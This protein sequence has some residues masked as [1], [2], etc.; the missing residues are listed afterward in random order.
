MNTVYEVENVLLHTIA[1]EVKEKCGKGHTRH[2]SS[3]PDYSGRFSFSAGVRHTPRA[4]A[5]QP[6]AN[7]ERAAGEFTLYRHERPATL[8][9][10]HTGAHRFYIAAVFIAILN[11][12]I[13]RAKT[14][15][16]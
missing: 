5:G 11:S 4:H 7:A 12:D 10:R 16:C 3:R 14:L 13:G 15:E 8:T 1:R 2:T 9:L 6:R